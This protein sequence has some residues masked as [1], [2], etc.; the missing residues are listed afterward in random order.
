MLM[1]SQNNKVEISNVTKTI[2]DNAK[3]KHQTKLVRDTL[4]IKK[5]NGKIELLT[6]SKKNIIF[7]DTLV[8]VGDPNEREYEYIGQFKK[9]GFYLVYVRFWESGESYL[10]NKKTGEQNILWYFPELSPQSTFFANTSLPYGL[11]G[12]QNGLQIWKIDKTN[13]DKLIKYF[14][15]D[16]N[17]WI[18][19]DLCWESDNTIILKVIE[20]EKFE[21]FSSEK[22]SEY[23]YLRLSIK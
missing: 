2:F 12:G 16:Q 3:A 22:E 21:F 13:H 19:F 1:H 4:T 18:P 11:D 17:K 10:I 20:A 23:S 9:A 15:I 6:T 8:E 7:K 5:V 14:E